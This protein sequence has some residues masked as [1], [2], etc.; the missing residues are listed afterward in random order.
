[1][2]GIAFRD[3][4]FFI[5][6]LLKQVSETLKKTDGGIAFCVRNQNPPGSLSIKYHRR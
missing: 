6:K 1:M 3:H 4:Y 2:M 5:L